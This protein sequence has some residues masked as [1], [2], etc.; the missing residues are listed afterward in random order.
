[1]LQKYRFIHNMGNG[2]ANLLLFIKTISAPL[3]RKHHKL[4]PLTH[5]KNNSAT[6]VNIFNLNFIYLFST[7]Y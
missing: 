7:T 2:E 5:S 6:K 1:M 3:E 4:M